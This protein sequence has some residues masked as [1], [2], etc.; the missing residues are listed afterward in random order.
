MPAKPKDDLDS[1]YADD[2]TEDHD[3][4]DLDL[5]KVSEAHHAPPDIGDEPAGQAL[6]KGGD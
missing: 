4:P 5:P 1:E 3:Q 6:K 2:V